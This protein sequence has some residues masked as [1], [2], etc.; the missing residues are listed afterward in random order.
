VKVFN[1]FIKALLIMTFPCLLVAYSQT[2]PSETNKIYLREHSASAK[3]GDIGNEVEKNSYDVIYEVNKYQLFL[4]DENN[5]NSAFIQNY[6]RLTVELLDDYVEVTLSDKIVVRRKYETQIALV[7]MRLALYELFLGKDYVEKNLEMLKKKSMERI[8]DIKR[9]VIK[10]KAIADRKKESKKEEPAK[11][12]VIKNPSLPTQ[13]KPK[14]A[15]KKIPQPVPPP[16]TKK[17]TPADPTATKGAETFEDIRKKP[18]LPNK[19]EPKKKK[20]PEKKDKKDKKK[21]DIKP[22]SD[23]SKGDGAKSNPPPKPGKKPDNLNKKNSAQS[24]DKAAESSSSVFPTPT[25]APRAK[26]YKPGESLTRNSFNVGYTY[27]K[28]RNDEIVDTTTSLNF[29][30]LGARMTS[31]LKKEGTTGFWSNLDYEARIQLSRNTSSDGGKYDVKLGR[32]IEAYVGDPLLNKMFGFGGTLSFENAQVGSIKA[33]GKGLTLAN[34]NAFFLGPEIRMSGE[35]F[36]REVSFFA[37]YGYAVF[38]N[39]NIK[40]ATYTLDKFYFDLS[41]YNTTRWGFGVRY[42]HF[43]GISKRGVLGNGRFQIMQ[44]TFYVLYQF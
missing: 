40:K 10:Q 2:P 16:V 7:D 15:D 4:T 30:T 23:S 31:L 21:N 22:N 33:L 38:N 8:K 44:S 27:L 9:L 25:S 14:P 11:T 12:A 13:K 37:G 28:G 26:A 29:V 39:T 20:E 18:K 19:P 17:E 32:R 6:E 1:L 36:K 24:S 3:F 34:V 43:D 42:D 35:F 5:R 41:Y